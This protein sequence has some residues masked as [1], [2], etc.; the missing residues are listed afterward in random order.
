[1]ALSVDL[2][3]C[4]EGGRPFA[5]AKGAWNMRWFHE[6][7]PYLREFISA[8]SQ[9]DQSDVRDHVEALCEDYDGISLI[10]RKAVQA[11]ENLHETETAGVVPAFVREQTAHQEVKLPVLTV[12]KYGFPWRVE[13]GRAGAGST[14]SK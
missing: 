13:Y 10:K 3:K 7:F 11:T 12:M 2:R 5:F 1:M 6:F 9:T 14:N 8:K 4:D